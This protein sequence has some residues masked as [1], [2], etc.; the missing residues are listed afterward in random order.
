ILASTSFGCSRRRPGCNGPRGSP[1]AGRLGA[2]HAVRGQQGIADVRLLVRCCD[3]AVARI[4]LGWTH[5][6]GED[7]HPVLV[8]PVEGGDASFTKKDAAVI[9]DA[10]SVAFTLDGSPLASERTRIKSVPD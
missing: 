8:S 5:F 7:W 6:C 10:I 2:R 3:S 1:G 4:A 9:L